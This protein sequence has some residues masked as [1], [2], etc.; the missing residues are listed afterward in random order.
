MFGAAYLPLAD[1]NSGLLLYL[2]RGTLMAQPFDARRLEPSGDPAP[3]VEGPIGNFY[4]YG[5]FSTSRNGTLTYWSP[6]AAQS[7]LTWFDAQGNVVRTIG[8]PGPYGD[9]ALSPDGARAVL[10][11]LQQLEEGVAAVWLLDRSRG[12]RT[13]LE[14][15]A[16]AR[17]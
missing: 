15:G 10:T 4:D 1:S 16:K 6:G 8:E 13:R 14:R 2:R 7:Q 17:Q 11:K 5:L 9:V 3:V 12:T